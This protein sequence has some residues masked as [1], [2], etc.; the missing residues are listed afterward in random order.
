MDFFL[1]GRSFFFDTF[2]QRKFTLR[3]L[4]PMA[5]EILNVE[6]GKKN[7]VQRQIKWLMLRRK[8][9]DNYRIFCL[10]TKTFRHHL[11]YSFSVSVLIWEANSTRLENF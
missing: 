11:P 4:W 9:V 8:H 3:L 6:I 2:M 1:H 7:P 10:F 5:C